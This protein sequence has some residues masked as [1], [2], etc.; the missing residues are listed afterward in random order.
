MGDREADAISTADDAGGIQIGENVALEEIKSD[1]PDE[2]TDSR[3]NEEL[4]CTVH[5][6]EGNTQTGSGNTNDGSVSDGNTKDSDTNGSNTNVADNNTN[7]ADGDEKLCACTSGCSCDDAAVGDRLLG[8][9]DMAKPPVSSSNH[10]IQFQDSSLHSVDEVYPKSY[11]QCKKTSPKR[12]KYSKYRNSML[13]FLPVRTDSKPNI[14]PYESAGFFSTITF[15]WIQGLMMK[16]YR[17]GLEDD[18]IWACPVNQSADTNCRRLERLWTEELEKKGD[19]ASFRRVIFRF[20]KTRT[21]VSG[22]FLAIHVLISFV[23]PAY[24][25]HSILEYTQHNEVDIA[26]GVG[27]AVGLSIVELARSLSAAISFSMNY[28]TGVQLRGAVLAIVYQKVLRLRSLKDK[29]AGQLVN[30]FSTDAQ[31]MFDVCIS[32]MNIISGPLISLV[33]LVYLLFLLG[34]IVIFGFLVIFCFYPFQLCMSK[35]MSLYRRKAVVITDQRVRLM[36]EILTCVKLIKMYAWEKPFAKT[37]AGIR[38][39]EIKMMEKSTY[40]QSMTMAFTPGLPITAAILTLIAHTLLGNDLTA[41]QAFTLLSV[42]NC[43][44]PKLSVAPAA[45]KSIIEARIAAKRYQDILVMEE[46]SSLSKPDDPDVAVVFKSTTLAWDVLPYATKEELKIPDTPLKPKRYLSESE[47]NNNLRKEMP[48][49]GSTPNTEIKNPFGKPIKKQKMQSTKKGKNQETRKNDSQETR[50]NITVSQKKQRCLQIQAEVSLMEIEK[51]SFEEEE[52]LEETESLEEKDPEFEEALFD[53]NLE[54]KKGSLIG[55]CG[56]VGCGKSSLLAA[57]MAQMKL[58]SGTIKV[59]GDVAYVAQ[60]AWIFNATV[61]ENIVYGYS[62]DEVRYQKILEACKLVSDLE[63]LPSGDETEIGERGINLSGGQK[64]RV[65]LARAVYS[66]RDIYLLDDPLSAV[67]GPVGH[68]IFHQ[69]IRNL[70]KEK[71]VLLVTHQLQYL[72]HCSQVL[73]MKDGRIVEA[74]HHNDLLQQ[75]KEYAAIIRHYSSNENLASEKSDIH[76]A[77]SMDEISI[78]VSN[79]ADLWT[80]DDM[81]SQSSHG[82]GLKRRNSA[83]CSELPT[84]C[85]RNLI[86]SMQSIMSGMSYESGEHEGATGKL[87]TAETRASGNIKGQ[88]YLSYVR[89]AGGFG[90]CFFVLFMFFIHIGC[91]GLGNWWLSYWLAQGSGNTSVTVDNVTYISDNISDNPQMYF[92]NSVHGAILIAILITTCIRSLLL[93]KCTLHASNTLH[94]LLFVKVLRSPMSF[95]DMT[96]TG[97]VLN[98]F[99]K[100]IDDT[101]SGLPILQESLLQNIFLVIL[102]IFMIVYVFPWFLVAVVPLVAIFYI[103][104]RIFRTG[105]RELKRVVSVTS[106]PIF[107]CVTATVQGLHTIKA[108]SKHKEYNTRFQQLL[109]ENTMPLFLHHCAKRWLTVRLDLVAITIILITALLIVLLK[110]EIPTAYSGLALNYALMLIGLF[111]FT[112]RM[113]FETETRFT[114]VERIDEYIKYLKSEAPSVIKTNRPPN[115]WPAEGHIKFENVRMRYRS[116]LPCILRGINIEISPEEKVGIVGRTGSGKSSLGVALFRLVELAAG[117]ITIDGVDI[118]EIGLEDLRTKLSIIPQDPVLFVGTIRYNLDPFNEHTDIELWDALRKCHIMEMIR[119]LPGRL[120]STVVEN[121][122]N[123]SVGER[124]LLCLAR[125]LLRQSKILMLDEATASIDSETDS[126]VQQTIAESFSGCTILTVAHRLNTVLNYDR[127]LVMKNGKVVEFDKPSALLARSNSTFSSMMAAVESQ[128]TL[129]DLQNCFL[130][131]R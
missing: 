37:I 123:F 107:S 91:T 101:D 41:A 19:Q 58:M 20:I 1:V 81:L 28:E 22:F 66:D 54:V 45:I 72:N 47:G 42:F 36:N 29:S 31:R 13:H 44:R 69:C 11:V 55:I 94:D 38:D 126:C 9:T 23:G 106:S 92:Y 27:L 26:Y 15:H 14:C 129:A 103:L 67:D 21:L 71:T 61:K 121:G 131:S 116:G 7:D 48:L 12:S 78:R 76:H 77:R 110:N 18:A 43:V 35:L 51:P 79:Q 65:S 118:S 122:E 117:S 62:W 102:S 40:V 84:S 108:Y 10:K 3:K 16:I 115:N 75:A 2:K 4:H 109:D 49:A 34:P 119:A 113:A 68:H 52:N 5:G 25:L 64:Q 33:A 17:R 97:R 50:K 73:L 56:S 120:D 6:N 63:M 130:D 128:S 80:L 111:Q 112:L 104:Q 46:S 83:S 82:S 93:M 88:T 86:H 59:C 53:L 125:A 30:L 8:N 60:Q 95:F 114:A 85:D 32:A 24:F 105:L 89:A 127:V 70:L 57:V 124:Q 74:G 39:A 100:D 99:S 96:P 90:V 98:R 87:I